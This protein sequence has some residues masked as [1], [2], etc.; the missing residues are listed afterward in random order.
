MI[1]F[2][3]CMVILGVYLQKEFWPKIPQSISKYRGLF[4]SGTVLVASIVL[5][6]P[7]NN[8]SLSFF[9]FLLFLYGMLTFIFDNRKGDSL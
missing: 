7:L 4:V 5:K 2:A 6:I 8:G 1:I 3:T 9:I